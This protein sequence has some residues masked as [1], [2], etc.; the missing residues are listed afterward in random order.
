VIFR[1]LY[2]PKAARRHG[3]AA[4]EFA[5]V[6]SLLILLVFGMIEFGR[7]L[8][9]QE[10]LV[11]A[12]REGAR[13]AVLPGATDAQTQTTVD[14]YLKNSGITTQTRSVSPSTDSASGGTA[15]TVT[16]SV[17]YKD[18][19]WLPKM[20]FLSSTNLSASVV[21]RKEDK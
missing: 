1:P 9:V 15:I 10:I 17:A 4:V 11:N 19:S 2:P 20:Q 5:F 18:V 12:A 13:K 6:A 16:V 7:M 21:M 8:M 14:D 3:A